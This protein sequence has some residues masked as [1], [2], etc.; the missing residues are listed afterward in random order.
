MKHTK[1]PWKAGNTIGFRKFIFNDKDQ[2]V[3]TIDLKAEN[4]ID[5]AKH[6]I[7]AAPEML[8]AL[9]NLENDSGKAMPPSAWKLVQDAI[10]KARGE[11]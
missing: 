5:E 7:A 9:E 8:E 1:G 11:P 10:K 6:L 4:E 2:K 3:C